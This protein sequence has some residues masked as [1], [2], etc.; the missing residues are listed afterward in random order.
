MHYALPY[1]HE[2]EFTQ[3]GDGDL[4]EVTR[5]VHE[6]PNVCKGRARKRPI[7]T[8]GHLRT[9]RRSCDARKNVGFQ[10]HSLFRCPRM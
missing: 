3:A 1:I 8:P 10:A 4:P 5:R 9:C 7:R 2:T 6:R